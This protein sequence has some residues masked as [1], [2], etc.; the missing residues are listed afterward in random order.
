MLVLIIYGNQTG[1]L[2]DNSILAIKNADQ[3]Y[4]RTYIMHVHHSITEQPCTYTR[5]R[6]V[7]YAITQSIAILVVHTI[8]IQ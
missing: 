3:K 7:M 8:L 4:E 2:T 5:I 6:L 1:F